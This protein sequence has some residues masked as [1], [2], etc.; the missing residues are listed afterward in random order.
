MSLKAF[1]HGFTRGYRARNGEVVYVDIVVG[2]LAYMAVNQDR[3]TAQS[4]QRGEVY[5]V[6][7]P[8]ARALRAESGGDKRALAIGRFVTDAHV[9]VVGIYIRMEKIEGKLRGN[10][11]G[12]VDARGNEYALALAVVHLIA[13]E[14][15]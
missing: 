10:R 8:A 2:N 12:E 7:R 9:R 4:L 3:D 5:G 6:F 1:H 14:G 13:R 11:F 15:D